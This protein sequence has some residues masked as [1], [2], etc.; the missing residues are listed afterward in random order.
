MLDHFPSSQ[1]SIHRFVL[2]DGRRIVVAMVR[3][4]LAVLTSFS[5][6]QQLRVSDREVGKF[7]Q[8]LDNIVPSIS[9]VKEIISSLIISTSSNYQPLIAHSPHSEL[10]EEEEV[11]EAKFRN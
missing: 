10:Q 11:V 7:L 4:L 6:S 1:V 9:I 5:P 8:L 3:I 2:L